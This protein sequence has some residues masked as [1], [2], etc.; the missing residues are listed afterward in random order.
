M[1]AVPFVILVMTASLQNFDTDI[2]LAALSCGASRFRAFFEVVLPNILPGLFS[3]AVLAFLA[4][5]DEVT[6]AIFISTLG[7]MTLPSKLF[8][9]INNTLTPVIASASTIMVVFSLLLLGLAEVA[10]RVVGRS[11]KIASHRNNGNRVR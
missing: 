4:S 10:R 8:E 11:A 2:E 1:L 5:F 9:D 7:Q 3:A 6:I